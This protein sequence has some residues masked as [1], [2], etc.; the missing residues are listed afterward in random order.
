MTT[1]RASGCSDRGPVRRT[2]EDAWSV[3]EDLGILVVA[4][5]M[6]GHAA[7]EVASR[8]AVEALLGFLRRTSEDADISWPYGIDAQLSL[9]ANRLRTAVHLANRRVFREAENHDDYT[10]MGTTIAAALV[11]G[12]LLSLAHVGDSRI[13]HLTNGTLVQ[14]TRDDSWAATVLG[15]PS[16][17]QAAGTQSM[18]HVLTNVLGR[19]RSDRGSYPGPLHCAW[20]PSPSLFRWLARFVRADGHSTAAARARL[21]RSRGRSAGASR[22][23]P[24]QPGQRDRRCCCLRRGVTIVVEGPRPGRPERIGRYRVLDRIGRGGMGV[25]YSAHDEVMER[26]VAV[27]VMMAD[28]DIEPEVRA[29][30]LRE[31]Q[32]SARLAHR[33]IVTIFDIGEDNGRLFIVMELLRGFTLAQTLKQRGI[34]LEEKVDLTLEVCEGLGFANGKGVCHRDVKPA[35]LFLLADGGVKLLDFGIARPTSS[36]MTATGAVLGTPDFMSPEQA[37]GTT[38][39]ERSDIFS[40]GAVLYL[41]L[42]G[43]TPFKVPDYP[44]VLHKVVWEDPPPLLPEEAPPALARIVV[45]ALAKEPEQRYQ[46]FSALSGELSRWRRRYAVGDPRI[47]RRSG[48]AARSTPGTGC[49]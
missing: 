38:C 37:K 43:R 40:V 36:N 1:L 41:M 30:F 14:L 27:K 9:N 31:A 5:G 12:D 18:R 13:Y 19:A 42:S 49:Q 8:L 2:N 33:N 16:E 45:K 4:D 47:R 22:V 20:G 17:P 21:G 34:A 29:R 28:P 35:N 7:G 32:V 11:S 39:D 44:A 6:G 23:G 26:D 15:R 3:D 46:D 24:R 25:V 10:G 48:A